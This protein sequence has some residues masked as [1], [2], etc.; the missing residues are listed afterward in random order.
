MLFEFWKVRSSEPGLHC[1]SG[2]AVLVEDRL[3]SALDEGEGSCIP[4]PGWV[5][6]YRGHSSNAEE[7]AAAASLLTAPTC[8]CFFNLTL[9]TFII[10]HQ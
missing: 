8:C 3:G 10:S 6:A 5:Y 1:M 9:V 7:F 4:S 2:P